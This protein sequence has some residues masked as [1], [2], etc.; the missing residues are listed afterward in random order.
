MRIKIGSIECDVR[1]GT[2]E[3]A[4]LVQFGLGQ[5]LAGVK[6][7]ATAALGIG[8]EL[9]TAADQIKLTEARPKKTGN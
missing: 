2:D 1:V 8:K 3:G 7:D 6:I 9:I 5:V 4:V